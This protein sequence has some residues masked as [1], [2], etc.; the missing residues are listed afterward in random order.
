VNILTETEIPIWA[1]KEISKPMSWDDKTDKGDHPGFERNNN[2]LSGAPPGELSE[3]VLWIIWYLRRFV[4]AD[5]LYSKKLQKK[6]DISQGQLSCLLAL[7]RYGPGSLSKLA[8][9]ILVKPG[10]VTGIID[11]LEAKGLVVRNR[12]FTDRRVI[13]I[14]LTGKGRAFAERAPAPVQR[15]II[16]GLSALSEEKLEAIVKIFQFMDSLI[17]ETP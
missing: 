5:E 14:E 9:R 7:Y 8:E 17:T 3:S 1:D 10:T 4:Q 12:S 15:S 6:F 2:D 11:R 16:E 13:T